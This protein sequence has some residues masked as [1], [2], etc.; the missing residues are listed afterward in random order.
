LRTASDFPF[1]NATSRSTAA[2]RDSY[3]PYGATFAFLLQ[4]A[5]HFVGSVDCGARAATLLTIVSTAVW[6]DLDVCAY[7]RDILDRLLTGSTAYDSLRPTCGN[8]CI[9]KPCASTEPTSAVTKPTTND[10]ASYLKLQRCICILLPCTSDRPPDSPLAT[11]T[12]HTV[13]WVQLPFALSQ[14]PSGV[15]PS[16][17]TPATP[18]HALIT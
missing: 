2:R 8:G 15:V 13:S 10:S 6:N 1:F 17:K 9:L 16:F 18:R 4:N 14:E 3:F 7:V 12:N 11:R 5:A